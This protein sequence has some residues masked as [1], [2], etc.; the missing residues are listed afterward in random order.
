MVEPVGK[1]LRLSPSR[2]GDLDQLCGIYAVVNAVQLTLGRSLPYRERL[3][4]FGA[5]TSALSAR[6]LRRALTDGLTS[7]ELLAAFRKN[8][9][10][11]NR[12]LG[13]H[14]SAPYER[15]PFMNLDHFLDRLQIDAGQEHH[16]AIL[17]LASPGRKHWT[18]LKRITRRS[19]A[20]YDSAGSQVI[21][22]SRICIY[23]RFRI[24]PARTLLLCRIRAGPPLSH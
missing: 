23:G 10:D 7:P 20:L 5:M 18:V 1:Q 8:E 24:E 12:A 2:Q 4:I 21:M 17:F 13:I 19:I 6:T 14:I 9:G 3:K 22:R 15:L 16:A 11:L